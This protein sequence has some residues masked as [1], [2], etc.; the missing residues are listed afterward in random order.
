MCSLRAQQKDEAMNRDM[1]DRVEER[2]VCQDVGMFPGG[3]AGLEID[4]N[5]LLQRLTD[6]HDKVGSPGDC[7]QID[8]QQSD[9]TSGRLVECREKIG[10]IIAT[11]ILQS[12]IKQHRHG[13]FLCSALRVSVALP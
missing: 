9:S 1:I 5:G 2:V 7:R 3:R 13:M 11:E 6:T 4:M 10:R 8:V 12:G